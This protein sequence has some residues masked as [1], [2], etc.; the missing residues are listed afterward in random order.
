[1]GF[2]AK[3]N[4]EQDS[5]E[6]MELSFDREQR[7]SKNFADPAL[8]E[9]IP[10][11]VPEEAEPH[12]SLVPETVEAAQEEVARE[13]AQDITPVD[14]PID[15][16]ENFSHFNI[17]LVPDLTEGAPQVDGH[18]AEAGHEAARWHMAQS[19]FQLV[20]SE[21]SFEDLVNASLR[22]MMDALHAEAGSIVE[23]D[24][25]HRDFFFRSAIGGA[26][27]PEKLKAFRVPESK[28]IVGHVAESRQPI[29]LRDLEE[30]QLQ[31]R[32]IGMGVGFEAKTC[33]AAPIV[34]GNQLYG[35]IEVFN[36]KDGKF[37]VEQDLRILEDGTRMI[38]KVLEVRFLMAELL[39][40]MGK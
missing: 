10:G 15:L 7:L 4:D 32:A 39:K 36:R 9:L 18:S 25:D 31:L 16:A 2:P 38:A 29:L 3:K 33:M 12:L 8:E 28:G 24:H 21:C 35:V 1:M 27:P 40:R 5:A 30:D 23:F 14:S 13:A 37:F 6:G 26:N 22:S 19:I 20:L 17:E 34:V 11:Y